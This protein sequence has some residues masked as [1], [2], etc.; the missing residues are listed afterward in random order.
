M[1]AGKALRGVA[2]VWAAVG[3][4][5]AAA[6]AALPVPVPELPAVAG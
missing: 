3:A 6:V 1:D 2:L 5:V 4:A